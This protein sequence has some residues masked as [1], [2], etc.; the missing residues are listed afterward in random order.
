M[1]DRLVVVTGGTGLL[2]EIIVGCL[3]KIGF[4]VVTI[5]RNMPSKPQCHHLSV[6]LLDLQ[7]VAAALSLLP[8][9]AVIIHL[10]AIAHGQRPP[11]NYTIQSANVKMLQNIV[12][13]VENKY[14]HWFFASS[15]SVYGEDDL[16]TVHPIENGTSPSSEYARSKVECENI[17]FGHYKNV[18]VL[19]LAPVFSEKVMVD[20]SKRVYCP[21]TKVRVK[22]LPAPLHSVCKLSTVESVVS[23]LI[24][25]GPSGHWIHQLA[26]DIPLSQSVIIEWFPG[27]TLPFPFIIAHRLRAVCEIIPGK[28]A[29][30]IR[31]MLKKFFY[32]NIYPPA[33]SLK[34]GL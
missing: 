26:E 30:Y 3:I 15:V 28:K 12:N 21:G 19:R 18:D 4:R 8:D 34:V 23:K 13:C 14:V 29:F 33:S 7:L 10:A 6:D 11:K 31:C 17:V 25:R 22:V 9:I 32:D 24:R 5:G 20:I 2:G 16:I 27:W 1:I